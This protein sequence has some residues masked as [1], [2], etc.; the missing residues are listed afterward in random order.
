MKKGYKVVTPEG[1]AM[2]WTY[3]TSIGK[4][5]LT[6]SNSQTGDNESV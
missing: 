4:G 1:F 3:F 2:E 6:E 5:L